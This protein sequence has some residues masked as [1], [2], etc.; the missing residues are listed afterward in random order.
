[1]D[2]A[3]AFCRGVKIEGRRI[4]ARENYIS[5]VPITIRVIDIG[6]IDIR[7]SH[8]GSGRMAEHSRKKRT[9]IRHTGHK[10]SKARRGN[11]PVR[12]NQPVRRVSNPSLR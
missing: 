2:C 9:H 7:M 3:E 8:G 4:P 5:L 1:M 12:R 11:D 6:M 10:P